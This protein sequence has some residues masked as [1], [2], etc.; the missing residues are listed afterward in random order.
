MLW[1]LDSV[2]TVKKIPGSAAEIE[3]R[4][5]SWNRHHEGFEYGGN[6]GKQEQIQLR[7]SRVFGEGFD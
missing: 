4:D 3:L 6:K 7:P 1:T 2:S 5:Q